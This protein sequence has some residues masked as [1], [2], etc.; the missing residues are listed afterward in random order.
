MSG[1]GL[2]EASRARNKVA[3]HLH[4]A[5]DARGYEKCLCRPVRKGRGQAKATLVDDNIAAI[6]A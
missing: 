5:G 2:G 4:G 3:G 6:A 1:K